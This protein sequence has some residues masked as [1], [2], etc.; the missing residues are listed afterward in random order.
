MGHRDLTRSVPEGAEPPDWLGSDDPYAAV[1]IERLPDWWHDAIVEF[2]AHDLP[3]YQ[4][5][6]FAADVL[7]PP[8]VSETEAA[9][10]TEIKL[11]GVNVNHGDAWGVWVNGEVAATVE[12][13]RTTDGYTLYEMTSEE[14]VA[15]VETWVE[16][17]TR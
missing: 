15:T 10:N 14:F 6:R 16:T 11:M 4:P 8:V 3:P 7:V 2:R 17:E 1:D 5:P 13:E 12:R 9:Y